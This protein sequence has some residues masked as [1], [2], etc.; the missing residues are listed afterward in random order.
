MPAGS[1]TEPGTPPLEQAWY[2]GTEVSIVSYDIE[3]GISHP[4]VM[5][6]FE[7][8]AGQTLPSENAPHLVLSRMPGM[9]FYSSIWEV[10]TVVV[11]DGVPYQSFKSAADIDGANL[12]IRSANVRLN[13]PVVAV[14]TA[15]ASG[16][17]QSIPF[18][19][20]H[21]LIRS[22]YSTGIGRF[23]PTTLLIDLPT[24]HR[25]HFTPPPPSHPPAPL[26]AAT[27]FPLQPCSRTS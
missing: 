27:P 11:P 13:C 26:S 6:K 10:W 8:A 4:Q 24:C 16:Q 23:H 19:N 14:E 12:R 18:E 3:D 21:D 22:N 7:N 1:T 25:V 2:N 9:P 5:F 20:F 17:F 15:P